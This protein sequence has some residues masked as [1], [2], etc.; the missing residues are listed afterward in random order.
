MFNIEGG[1]LRMDVS[2]SLPRVRRLIPEIFSS[3]L[4]QTLISIY[5]HVRSL[6]QV[7]TVSSDPL[8]SDYY[9]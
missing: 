5:S 9:I 8:R 4:I 2:P 6:V 1:N 7:L 3:L